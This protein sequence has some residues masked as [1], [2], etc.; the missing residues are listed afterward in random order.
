M[1]FK[2]KF[3]AVRCE[4]D[5]YKFASKKERTRYDELKAWQKSGIVTFFLMQ[6]PFH[7][8]AGVKYVCDFQ[9]FWANGDITFEDVKGMKTDIYKLK[10]KQVEAIYGVE[11]TEC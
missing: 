2:H 10:K 7:L 8:T 4:R 3:N 1:K 11:I 9:V 5:G 6:V